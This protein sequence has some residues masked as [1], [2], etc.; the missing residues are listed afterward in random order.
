MPEHDSIINSFV[1]NPPAE[2]LLTKII[3][4]ISTA[5]NTTPPQAI[6]VKNPFLPCRFATV[7]EAA[8]QPAASDIPDIVPSMPSET[9]TFAAIKEKTSRQRK[10]AP[11]QASNPSMTVHIFFRF[12]VCS[13]LLRIK[14]TPLHC[15]STE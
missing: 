3:P 15:R 1:K 7:Y 9:P 11:R 5:K 6:P 8:K 4:H 2:K 14:N 13:A 10:T 12:A